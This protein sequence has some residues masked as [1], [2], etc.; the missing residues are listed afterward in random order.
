MN[1]NE[2]IRKLENMRDDLKEKDIVVEAENGLLLPPEIKFKL[3]NPSDA[4][5]L[6]SENVEYILIK[7]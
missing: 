5:N 1:I 2:L 6:S 7:W 3:K 4:L